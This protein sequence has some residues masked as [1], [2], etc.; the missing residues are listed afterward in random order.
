MRGFL[1][2]KIMDLTDVINLSITIGLGIISIILGIFSIWLSMRFN[3]SSNKALDSVK[4]LSH[5]LKSLSEISLTH[6]KDF[7]SKMLDSLL[8]QGKYGPTTQTQ[9][10]E[11]IEDKFIE[12]LNKLEENISNTIEIKIKEKLQSNNISQDEVKE[13]LSE[14]RTETKKLKSHTINTARSLALPGNL[15]NQ[16]KSFI[17][18]P[19]NYL[20]IEAIT[21]E[22]VHSLEELQ[23][24]TEKYGIPEGWEDAIDNLAEREIIYFDE[25]HEKFHIPVK[26]ASLIKRWISGNQRTIEKIRVATKNKSEPTVSEKER[27]IA[28]ELTF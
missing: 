11:S 6:Q 1:K 5:D 14:I 7:S 10:H 23:A 28:L 8:D 24:V 27:A 22:N 18:Y 12:K 17:E 21:K 13:I 15:R 9:T 20:L 25:N 26:Q 3:E 19:A 16:L 4:S 2:G